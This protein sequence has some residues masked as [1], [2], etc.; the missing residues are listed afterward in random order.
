M[1]VCIDPQMKR[2]PSCELGFPITERSNSV[3]VP[4]GNS[5]ISVPERMPLVKRGLQPAVDKILATTTPWS[6]RPEAEWLTWAE[7]LELSTGCCVIP[8]PATVD[9]WAD[10]VMRHV[11]MFD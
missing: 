1:S 5:C 11:S 10:E 9:T 4:K 6:K 8:E 7:R 2:N 3:E